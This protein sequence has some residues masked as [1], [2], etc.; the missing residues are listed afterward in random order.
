MGCVLK[1]RRGMQAEDERAQGEEDGEPGRRP[2][3]PV[4]VANGDLLQPRPGPA[5]PGKL[6]PALAFLGEQY[7][8]STGVVAEPAVHGGE[9]LV[10]LRRVAVRVEAQPPDALER[11]K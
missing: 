2:Q 11:W 7:D 9:G 6:C 4:P 5:V 8:A 3:R 10:V 1:R